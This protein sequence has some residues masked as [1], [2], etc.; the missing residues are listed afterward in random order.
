MTPKEK[1]LGPQRT[2]ID[3]IDTKL[4]DLLSERSNLVQEVIE[5][6]IKNRLPIFAPEREDDKTDRFRRMAEQ[7]DLD[8]DWAE[9]FLRMI[10]ASSRASQSSNEFPCA[11]EKPKDILIVGAR[12]G[13]GSLYSRIIEQSGHRIHKIDKHNWHDLEEMA[14]QL[15]SEERRVGKARASGRVERRR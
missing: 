7:R 2:R 15:R 6:K 11:T 1:Q 4:L 9:D 5:K 8:P 12:G 10:M 14:P 3:E 13:M